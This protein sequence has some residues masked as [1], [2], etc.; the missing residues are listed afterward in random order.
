[1]NTSI[2]QAVKREI[3]RRGVT[4]YAFARDLPNVHRMTVLGWLYSGRPVSLAM[5]E[6]I[7]RALGLVVVPRDAVVNKKG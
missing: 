6:R 7:M 1:M 5:G 2:R 4:P 3:K